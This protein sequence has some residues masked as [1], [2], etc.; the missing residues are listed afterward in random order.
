MV[1][2]LMMHFSTK[3]TVKLKDLAYS[4]KNDLTQAVLM[5]TSNLCFWSENKENRIG[6]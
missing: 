4:T 6:A 2:R 1:V 5:S 3:Y